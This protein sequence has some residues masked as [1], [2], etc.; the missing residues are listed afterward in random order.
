MPRTFAIF[1]HFT[2]KM[3]IIVFLDISINVKSVEEFGSVINIQPVINDIF[4]GKYFNIVVSVDEVVQENSV[5]SDYGVGNSG[6][7]AP[8]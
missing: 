3:V 7:T 6:N 2:S 5:T 4:L 8:S 1:D